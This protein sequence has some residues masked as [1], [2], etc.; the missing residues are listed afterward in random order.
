MSTPVPC[1]KPARVVS[2]GSTWAC[3]WYGAVVAVGLAV[4]DDVVGDVAR[5]RVRRRRST[6]AQR[7]AHGDDVGRLGVVEVA[8]VGPGDDQQLVGRRRSRTGTRRPRGRPRT[9]LRWPAST[10]ASRV[11]HS[12]QPPTKRPEAVLLLGQLLGHER[13]A[14]QLAVGVVERGARLAAVV[15][16]GLRVADAR[17]GGVVL[18]PVPQR[19]H[20]QRRPGGRRGRPTRR[21]GRGRGPAPRG[22]R[23]PAPGE[24]RPEV[25][26]D[27]RLG[28]RERGVAVG[29]HPDLPRRRRARRS[30]GRAAWPPRCPG[31]NGHGPTG[32]GL[33]RQAARGEGRRPGRPLGG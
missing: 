4:E 23:W 32:V 19:G 11:V 29:H 20:D 6:S 24:H 33:H 18:D 12:R 21:R 9:T 17:R 27:Q 28:A 10:S 16:D 5:R 31:Q 15:D 13:D 22:C 26:D 30:R 25:A 8:L 14:E 2:R 3:Q 7:P 1:S